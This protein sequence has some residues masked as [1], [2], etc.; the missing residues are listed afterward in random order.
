MTLSIG[1]HQEQGSRNYQEDRAAV[2]FC[3][4]QE[5]CVFYN[6]G[7]CP[8]VVSGL[9]GAI[10]DGHSGEDASKYLQTY[11]GNA[12]LKAVYDLK[13]QYGKVRDC[14]SFGDAIK[15]CFAEQ[16]SIILAE[17]AIKDG[18][19][20]ALAMELVVVLAVDT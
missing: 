9:V 1:G 11:L 17:D 4:A 20:Q 16:D 15:R 13:R 8:C 18:S 7:T 19:K 14:K 5:E 2:H 10:Y 6:A 3:R 12:V